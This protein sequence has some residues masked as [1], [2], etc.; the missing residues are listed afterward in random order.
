M[1]AES[2]KSAD[3]REQAY[4]L[5]AEGEANQRK[6]AEGG[7]EGFFWGMV[8]IAVILIAVLGF[9]FGLWSFDCTGILERGG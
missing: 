4:R 1:A 2:D 6:D 9:G 7:G 5:R 3:W 8:A